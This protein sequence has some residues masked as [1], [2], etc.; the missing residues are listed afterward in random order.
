MSRAAGEKL[1]EVRSKLCDMFN[2]ESPEN[3]AFTMNTTYALNIAIKGLVKRGE[4]ILISDLEHNSVLRSVVSVCRDKNASYDVFGTFYGDENK[5]LKDI[6]DKIKPET[7]VIVCLHASNIC[8]IVLPIKRIGMFCR[9]REIIFIVDAAQSAGVLDI[10][11]K[12]DFID[13]LCLPAHKS[14]YGP[15]GIA[16]TVFGNI[17]PGDIETIIE[18]G[19]GT[20]SA[21]KM[22]PSYLPDRIEAGTM[23]TPSAAGF[24]AGIDFVLK[25]GLNSIRSYESGLAEELYYA[26]VS[27]RRF[28]V[29]THPRGSSTV[30]FNVK[31]KPSTDTAHELDKKGIC[32]R[33]GFHCS[34]LAHKTLG[35]GDSGAVRVSFGIF[36]EHREVKKLID[37]LIKIV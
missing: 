18:G 11:L 31:G 33:A 1:F 12:R 35:T 32:V 36:N 9:S 15:Q 13:V 16:A 6:A 28:I 14:M 8:G 17:S 24:S 25:N 34:P 22:M 29:Y 7:K 23:P 30:L 2:V 27:D 20:N 3:I 21:D 37:T 10:D 19:S 5:I 4:H 26:L